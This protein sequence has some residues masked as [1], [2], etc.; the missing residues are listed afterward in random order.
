MRSCVVQNHLGLARL[1]L[2]CS[3]RRRM[4]SRVRRDVLG[5]A[6]APIFVLY[7]SKPHV[8]TA[9]SALCCGTDSETTRTST[10]SEQGFSS[11]RS[12][13]F[14]LPVIQCFAYAPPQASVASVGRRTSGTRVGVHSRRPVQTRKQHKSHCGFQFCNRDVQREFTAARTLE[15][16]LRAGV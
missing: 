10:V 11:P 1:R 4:S 3:L 7:G 2:I 15:T 13:A 12:P 16:W 8:D 6:N 9:S 5:T 14:D